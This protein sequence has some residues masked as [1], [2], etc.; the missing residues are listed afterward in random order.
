M[1]ERGDVVLVVLL[2]GMLFG[3]LVTW[4]VAQNQANQG[5]IVCVH[6]QLSASRG[7]GRDERAKRVERCRIPTGMST[8]P[9]LR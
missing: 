2:F 1:S 6:E 8:L 5:A 3:G 7:L 4:G 9:R